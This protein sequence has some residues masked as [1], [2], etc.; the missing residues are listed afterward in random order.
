MALSF[1]VK[2]V[3]SSEQDG[4]RE[5]L[6]QLQ[7][8]RRIIQDFTVTTLAAIPNVFLRLSYL[9]SLRNPTTGRYEH[10]GLTAVYGEAAVEQALAAC[11]EE[12]LEKIL[13]TPLAMQIEDL[14]ACLGATEDGLLPGIAQ[15]QRREVYQS[16]LPDHAPDYLR[17][18]FCS[19]LRALLE[20]LQ[21]DLSTVHSGA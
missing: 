7:L 9:A 2:N 3:S 16:L 14:L 12:I 1:P 8:N 11:H 4:P 5:M 10:P 17:E 18:L 21:K 19:N 20:I 13:E 15:W 6:R